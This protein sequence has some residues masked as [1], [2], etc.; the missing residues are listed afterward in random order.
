MWMLGAGRIA[1][2][3][4]DVKSSTARRDEMEGV[5]WCAMASLAH[6]TMPASWVGTTEMSPANRFALA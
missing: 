1:A 2:S 5:G 4:G 6:P 3:F